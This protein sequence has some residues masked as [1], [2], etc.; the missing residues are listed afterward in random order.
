MS[1]PRSGGISQWGMRSALVALLT[2]GACYEPPLCDPELKLDVTYVATV[3]EIYNQQSSAQYDSRFILDIAGVPSCAGFDGLV[4][5]ATI[6]VRTTEAFRRTGSCRGMEGVVLSLP[7]GE[8]WQADFNAGVMG[9]FW[10]YNIF[11]AQGEVVSGPCRGVYSVTF[12]RPVQHVS[13]FLGTNPGDLP[14]MVLGRSFLP[15]DSDGGSN[16]SMCA[17]TF[18]AQLALGK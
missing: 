1:F 9:A 4:P 3:S 2:C 7:N 5:G 15:T 8:Q 10:Q 18:V 12:G 14:S 6:S 16:C 13:V 11:T 17:D